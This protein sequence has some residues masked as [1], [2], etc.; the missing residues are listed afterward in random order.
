MNEPTPDEIETIVQLARAL[1]LTDI[2]RQ[3]Y[4][5]QNA[6]IDTAGGALLRRMMAEIG[7]LRAMVRRMKQGH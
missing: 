5:I 4:E 1:P 6:G 7:A 3:A 2:M